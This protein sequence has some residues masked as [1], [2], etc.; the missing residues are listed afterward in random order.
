M[1]NE[2]DQE[3]GADKGKIGK[4]DNGENPGHLTGLVVVPAGSAREFRR[5][6]MFHVDGRFY[7]KAPYCDMK[8]WLN[9]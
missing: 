3:V 7:D 9:S 4:A 2:N 6:G 1:Y 5:I 8:S